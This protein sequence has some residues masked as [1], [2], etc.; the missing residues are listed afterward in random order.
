MLSSP[1]ILLSG[2]NENSQPVIF[3]IK[4]IQNQRASHNC[5][6]VGQKS[7]LNHFMLKSS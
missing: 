6:V 5:A 3:V 2:A 7:F 1:F 4:T